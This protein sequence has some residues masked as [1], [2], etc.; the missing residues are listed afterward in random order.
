MYVYVYNYVF[1]FDV[2]VC[3]HT[4]THMYGD[5]HRYAYRHGRHGDLFRMFMSQ[6]R[7]S[8]VGDMTDA[9]AYN[10]S[11]DVLPAFLNNV[12]CLW[13]SIAWHA[14]HGTATYYIRF[15]IFVSCGR[16]HSPTLE[17]AGLCLASQ[18]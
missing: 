8:N 6:G 3:T 14:P 12:F 4:H 11:D 5:I 7:L 2:Y 18:S 16:L 13:N 10:H 9:D 17:M 15:G 1:E